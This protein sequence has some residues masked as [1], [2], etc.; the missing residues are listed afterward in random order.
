[1]ISEDIT[2]AEGQVVK[3]VIAHDPVGYDQGFTL[4]F[5][6]GLILEVEPASYPVGDGWA[7]RISIKETVKKK[8]SMKKKKRICKYPDCFYYS[9]K[10]KV[11]CCA[12]CSGDHYDKAASIILK[13]DRLHKTT[14]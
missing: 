14:K 7:D 11:Y 12:A 3:K 6:S 10:S 8:I 9:P 5:E 2:K 4:E 1:M 13:Y